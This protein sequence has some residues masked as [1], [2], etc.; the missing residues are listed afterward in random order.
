[1]SF[2]P[3]LP[4]PEGIHPGF[5]AS[6]ARMH[7]VERNMTITDI[8]AQTTIENLVTA[9]PRAVSFLMEHGIRC[10]L[11]GEPAWGTLGDAMTDKGFS[12]DR[13]EELVRLLRDHLRRLTASHDVDV[14][15]ESNESH[16]QDI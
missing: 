10:I 1:M 5:G 3:R 15:A 4:R 9:H 14:S 2:V 12:S 11:C 6:H 8:T 7:N 13:K 16:H